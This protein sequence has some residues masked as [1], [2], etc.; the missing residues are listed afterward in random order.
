MTQ[1]GT[2]PDGCADLLK[3]LADPT[4]LAVVRRLLEGPR[5][6]NELN[7]GIDVDQSLL[8]HHLKVL[9]DAGVVSARRDG[10]AVLYRIT[11]D[12]AGRKRRGEID[13]GCCRLNFDAAP[14][15]T[16]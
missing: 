3:A 14:S 11:E 9:R 10:R 1:T 2:E 16:A 7:A 5:H 8:S 12:F 15:K 4:R 13:L 6:V